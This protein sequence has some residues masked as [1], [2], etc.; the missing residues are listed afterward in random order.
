MSASKNAENFFHNCE[1]IKGW[2]A[3]KEYVADGATFSCQEAALAEVS[4]VKDYVDWMTG[5]GSTTAPGCSYDLHASAYDEDNNTALFFATFNGTHTGE[6]GPVPPT[7]KTTHSEYVY[8][9]QMNAEGKVA[10]MTKIWN[11]GWAM[12]ELG[13]M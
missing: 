2:E 9:L 8:A 7:N 11:G 12:G 13:W 10:K 4:T 1:S 3:C 5:I 6:G